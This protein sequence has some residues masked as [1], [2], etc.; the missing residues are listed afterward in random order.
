MK[1]CV[2]VKINNMTVA[3][4]V[5]GGGTAPR[6]C[7]ALSPLQGVRRRPADAAGRRNFCQN[8]RKHNGQECFD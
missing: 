5:L 7:W 3:V 6:S 2:S 4:L 1:I 8:T